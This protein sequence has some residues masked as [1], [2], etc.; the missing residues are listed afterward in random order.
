MITEVSDQEK[1]LFVRRKA[2]FL[3]FSHLHY[4]FNL[5]IATPYIAF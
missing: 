1:V 4:S 5:K 3:V 2:A